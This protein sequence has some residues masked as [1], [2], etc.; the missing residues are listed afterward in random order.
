MLEISPFCVECVCF[1]E[2]SRTQLDPAH[3]SMPS[4]PSI[5]FNCTRARVQSLINSVERICPPP[6][7]VLGLWDA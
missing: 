1:P 3:C 6:L 5:I 2:G 4:I 7:I